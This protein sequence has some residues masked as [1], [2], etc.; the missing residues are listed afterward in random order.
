MKLDCIFKIG[1][2]VKRKIINCP[3]VD[4]IRKCLESITDTEI[5]D[6]IECR[7]II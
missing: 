5:Y 1:D 7:E 2:K 6:K 4:T 3:N